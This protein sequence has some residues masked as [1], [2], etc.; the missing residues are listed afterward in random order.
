MKISIQSR[1]DYHFDHP[2]DVLLQVEAAVIPEQLVDGFINLTQVDHFARIA[3]HDEIGDRIWLRVHGQLI[4]DY[5]ATVKIDR[6]LRD[7]RHLPMVP[8]HKLPGETVQYL[9][10]SRYCPSDQFQNFVDADFGSFEGGE[11][12]AVM[13]DWV[14]KHFS[15]VPGSSSGDT[16]ALDTFV[17]RQGVCRDYAHVMVTLVRASGIPARIASVYAL[18]VDPQDFHAVAEVFLDGAWH[19]VDATGM[20]TEGGMAKIGVGRD[21]ADV[22]FLTAYGAAQ[23]NGQWVDVR[24]A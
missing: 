13:R 7:V 17:K 1:L 5:R 4:V 15:Y 19:L 6:M 2:T 16:T 9:M 22:A 8:P 18:G 11:R 10:P 12:V 3:A 21:A 23:M 24:P 14:E 20:A